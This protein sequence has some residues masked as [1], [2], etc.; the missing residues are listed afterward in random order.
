MR[1]ITTLYT[2]FFVVLSAVFTALPCLAQGKTAP[3]PI[4]ASSIL[5][6]SV[7]AEVLSKIRT[8]PVG[9]TRG[10]LEHK[11]FGATVGGKWMPPFDFIY[12]IPPPTDFQKKHPGYFIAL[13]VTFGHD[14]LPATIMNPPGMSKKDK[15]YNRGYNSAVITAIAPPFITRQTEFNFGENSVE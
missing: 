10:F 5:N 15:R 6:V 8:I 3:N 14:Y 2:G 9:E 7:P 12:L 1:S 13:R 11:L 4:V